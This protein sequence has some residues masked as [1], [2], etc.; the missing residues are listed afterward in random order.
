MAKVRKKQLRIRK[1]HLTLEE[2]RRS[3]QRLKEKTTCS[4]CGQRGRW[5][6]SPR[7]PKRGQKCKGSSPPGRQ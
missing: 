3:L 1:M 6:G 7:C 5:A 2:R 4:D